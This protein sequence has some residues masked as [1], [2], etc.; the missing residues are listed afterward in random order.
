M[1]SRHPR[2]AHAASQEGSGNL[3][4]LFKKGVFCCGFEAAIR[5]GYTIIASINGPATDSL[6]NPDRLAALADMRSRRLTT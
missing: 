2:A 5:D 3:N 1:G 4:K 6:R